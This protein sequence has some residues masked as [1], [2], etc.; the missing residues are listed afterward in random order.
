MDNAKSKLAQ[1]YIIFNLRG[2]F[3]HYKIEQNINKITIDIFNIQ[4]LRE[5][6]NY[7]LE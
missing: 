1:D 3:N 6:V 5:E 4:D 7:L 2:F